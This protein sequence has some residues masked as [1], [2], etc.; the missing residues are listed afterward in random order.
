MTS[1]APTIRRHHLQRFV[2]DFKEKAVD[3]LLRCCHD[4]NIE[5]EI[6]DV[7]LEVPTSAANNPHTNNTHL[8]PAAKT[9]SNPQRA[10]PIP[11][12]HHRQASNGYVGPNEAP[13]SPPKTRSNQSKSISGRDSTENIVILSLTEEDEVKKSVAIMKLAQTNYSVIGEHMIKE[14]RIPGNNVEDIDEQW[15]SI[16]KKGAP[17]SSVSVKVTSCAELTWKR[18]KPTRFMSQASHSTVFYLV[19]Q[20]LLDIDVLLG[21]ADSGEGMW[22]GIAAL[23]TLCM[24]ADH[25]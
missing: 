17:G 22:H 13:P 2:T 18:M 24:C 16:P 9:Y 12:G 20:E 10:A 7:L 1:K 21:N 6:V 15:I 5:K 14:G 19:A 3:I 23:P 25:R 8:P 4:E 11:S